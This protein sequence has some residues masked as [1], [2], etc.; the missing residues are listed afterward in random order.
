MVIKITNIS[1][2]VFFSCGGLK[3]AYGSH[4]LK[5]IL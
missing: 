5:Y 3:C 4:F 2:N 1:R